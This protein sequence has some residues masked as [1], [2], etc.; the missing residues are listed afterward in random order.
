MC[1]TMRNP[2]LLGFLLVLL[3]SMNLPA[4]RASRRL[5]RLRGDVEAKRRKPRVHFLFLAVDRIQRLDIWQRFFQG[6]SPDEFSII[7]HCKSPHKCRAQLR[8]AGREEEW[9]YKPIVIKDSAPTAYCT[10]LVSAENRLLEEA[11]KISGVAMP[12]ASSLL[13]T[14]ST[15]EMQHSRHPAPNDKFVLLSDSTLPVKPFRAVYA[16]LTAKADSRWCIFPRQEWAEAPRETCM[17]HNERCVAWAAAN[18]CQ[19]N[20]TYMHYQCQKSCQVC[21]DLAVMAQGFPAT[22]T[23]VA[24]KVH[25]W[26][27]LNQA[28]ALRSV[29]LWK[30]GYLRHLMQSLHL[31]TAPW[32][33][34][35]RNTGCLDEY[36]HFAALYGVF[37]KE[38]LGKV[39]ANEQCSLWVARGEC[40]TNPNYMLHQCEASCSGCGIPAQKFHLGEPFA[41]S[42]AVNAGVQG[43]CDTFVKWNL[44]GAMG[45]DNAMAKLDYDLTSAG[46]KHVRFD[47]KTNNIRPETITSVSTWTLKALK[48]SKFLFARKF[49]ASLHVV[50]ACESTADTWSREVFGQDHKETSKAKQ[51]TWM[52]D[53]FWVD[54]MGSKLSIFSDMAKPSH[55]KVDNP[56]NPMW[57][58]LGTTC[59]EKISIVFHNG[60]K[61]TG[62]FDASDGTTIT[63]TNGAVWHRDLPWQGDGSWRDTANNR[64]TIRTRGVPA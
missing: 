17:D 44:P 20:P 6:A 24:P 22:S 10:D 11:L 63:F 53:G 36:W 37:P 40:S 2:A 25:E 19:K 16:E 18:E 46:G 45:T 52:G 41:F 32:G 28:D 50:D 9:P 48:E 23:M 64:V 29:Q 58:G 51:Q 43:Q 26:K 7:L 61:A 33:H 56:Q 13:S 47:S 38:C 34:R 60:K 49:K 31:N 5:R 62:Y 15:M 27:T 57:A 39:D 55:V 3:N 54:S 35:K 42:L 1:F 12:G 8:A 59:G 4:T 30:Q 21:T 14:N